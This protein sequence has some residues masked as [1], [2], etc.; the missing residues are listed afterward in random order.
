MVSGVTLG[1]GFVARAWKRSSGGLG[2]WVTV[3]PVRSAVFSMRE[4]FA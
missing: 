4:V 2:V 3:R 1:M